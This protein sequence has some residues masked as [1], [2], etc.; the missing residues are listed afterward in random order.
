MK[1][2]KTFTHKL[3][4]SKDSE[5]QMF[6]ISLPQTDL[7]LNPTPPGNVFFADLQW[8]KFSPCCSD[9]QVYSGS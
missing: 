6:N 8:I 2:F 7:I 4:S 1:E 9:A 5:L 3:S